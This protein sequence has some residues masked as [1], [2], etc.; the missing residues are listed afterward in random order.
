[1]TRRNH[2]LVALALGLATTTLLALGHRRVGYVRDEGIYFLA[3]RQYAAWAA[4]LLTTP[5]TTLAAP[6]RAVDPIPDRLVVLTFDDASKSHFTGA[7]SLRCNS[8]TR[9]L[10]PSARPMQKRDWAP[11]SAPSPERFSPCPGPC[12]SWPGCRSSPG[13]DS[14]V[15]GSIWAWPSRAASSTA[16]RARPPMKSG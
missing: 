9:T 3:S 14:S 11:R 10:R 5:S 2:L 6:A 4:N 12:A 7:A 16:R 1:M 13:W 8:T 15:C